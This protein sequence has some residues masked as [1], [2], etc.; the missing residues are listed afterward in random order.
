M[1][2]SI[3]MQLSVCTDDLRRC[4]CVF[5]IGLQTVAS[6]EVWARISIIHKLRLFIHNPYNPLM[7]AHSSKIHE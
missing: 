5:L 1:Y 3:H 7:I 6:E 4:L 2:I